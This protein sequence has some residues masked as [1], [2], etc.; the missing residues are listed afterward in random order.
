M[1]DTSPL[2][3][4]PSGFQ[5]LDV[6]FYFPYRFFPGLALYFVIGTLINR[7]AG[8]RGKEMIPHGSFWLGLPDL[9]MVSYPQSHP[10]HGFVALSLL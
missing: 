6:D 5:A 1:T 7:M 10:L 4:L 3:F 9:I 2:F 8:H